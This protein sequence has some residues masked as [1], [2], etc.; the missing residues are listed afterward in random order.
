MMIYTSSFDKH[1]T[2]IDID[3]ENFNYRKQKKIY[4]KDSNVTFSKVF[5]NEISKDF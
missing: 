4:G 2:T 3:L 5:Q 1:C